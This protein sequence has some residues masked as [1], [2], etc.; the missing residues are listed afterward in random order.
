M[1]SLVVAS[2]TVATVLLSLVAPRGAV[3]VIAHAGGKG[4]A[5]EHTVAAYEN[6]LRMEAD[7]VELDLN[8][9][10]DGAL[11]A[12]HDTTLG[13]TT[14]VEEV[15][16][17]RP[18]PWMIADFTLD[19]IKR[20]DAGA[21]F[22]P[23]FA[24]E[25]V[26]TLEEAI[27]VIGGRAGIY[28]ETKHPYLYPGMEERILEVLRDKGLAGRQGQDSRV[29]LESFFEP[30]LLELR[31]LA[32]DVVLVQ[33]YNKDTLAGSDLARLFDRAAAYAQGVGPEWVEVDA[34]L[35]AT[36][37]ERGLAVHAWT[38]NEEADLVRLVDLGVDGIFTDYP[39]RLGDIVRERER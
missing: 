38:I 22:G 11:I 37:H 18:A 15:F 19:E 20:L 12:M 1:G 13:R 26:P 36:A 14:N 17:D 5:P 23:E 28:I 33:L 25:R 7:Y 34:R 8:M 30:S 32:P 29:I 24:S 39:D 10:R 31:R 35:V 3:A 21:W 9:T 27:D 6:A 16:P 4:H 2:V